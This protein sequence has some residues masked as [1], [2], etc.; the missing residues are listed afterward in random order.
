MLTKEERRIFETHV[1]R[2]QEILM[3]IQGISEDVAHLVFEHHEDLSGQ[4]YPFSK[5]RS[6][7]HPLSKI[8]QAVNIFIE[9]A[10]SHDGK[11]MTGA[12]AFAYMEKICDMRFDH[13]V[14]AAIKTLIARPA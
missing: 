10:L 6:E 13:E 12:N 2:G 14:I 4:G 8:L 1:V 9:H 11:G 7:L 3:K 5:K